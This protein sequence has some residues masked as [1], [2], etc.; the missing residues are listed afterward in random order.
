M[1][2]RKYSL[3]RQLLHC[4]LMWSLLAAVACS[5]LATNG[6]HKNIHPG[7]ISTVDSNAYDTLL[8][9]QAALDE[10][11]KTIAEN[12][13]A[14]YKTAFNSAVAVYN[15]AEAD[16]QLYHRTKDPALATKLGAEINAVV[17]TI[18][19]MRKTFGKKVGA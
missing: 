18:A 9:A 1:H 8:I 12:P 16:W 10:G 4:L 15:Q 6:C 14:E 13:S 17:V 7:A 11:R 3:P 2:Q 19:N 5:T